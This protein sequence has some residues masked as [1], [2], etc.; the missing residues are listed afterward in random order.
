[1]FIYYGIEKH[2][3]TIGNRISVLVTVFNNNTNQKEYMVIFIVWYIL[4]NYHTIDNNRHYQFFFFDDFKIY[5][6]ATTHG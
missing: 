6:L 2:D 5:H 3:S 4:H 1:M